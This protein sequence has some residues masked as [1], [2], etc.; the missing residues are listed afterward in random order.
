MKHW[1]IIIGLI[2]FLLQAQD[3]PQQPVN[4]VTD[5]AE[6]LTYEEEEKLN[7][8]LKAFE[9]SSA[10]Q[11]FIYTANSL[12][13]NNLEDLSRTIFNT[14]KIGQKD[15]NN[16]ILIAVF[17]DDRKFRIQVGLGLEQMLS[18]DLT[19]RIQDGEMKP[20]FK[21]RQY[22]EGLDIGVDK[23]IYYSAHK[24]EWYEKVPWG[25]FILFL[26][27]NIII[28][29]ILFFIT[30]SLKERPVAQKTLR[31]LSGIFLLIPFIGAFL[32]IILIIIGAVMHKGNSGVVSAAAD[33]DQFFLSS[34]HRHREGNDSSFS[35]SDSSFDGGG[36][37]SSD[38]GGS[39]SDW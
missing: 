11:L 14:W 30:K 23:L 28:F 34:R 5:N 36:G 15:K 16:G 21:N 35:S 1:F 32:M 20:L 17:I 29:V 25:L 13:D 24:A 3:F 6:I 12:N 39:S 26:V 4:Y 22:Y 31:I 8:K 10:N 19:Q 27:F 2:P 9:E 33:D 37:G 18:S 7:A 38:S